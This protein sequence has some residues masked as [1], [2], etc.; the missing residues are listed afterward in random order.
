MIA[1]VRSYS[2]FEE[3]VEEWRH[4]GMKGV[5]HDAIEMAG[6]L[7]VFVE[8]DSDA[9]LSVLA[10]T[11]KNL[12]GIASRSDSADT[13]RLMIAGGPALFRKLSERGSVPAANLVAAALENYYSTETMSV[14]TAS[15]PISFAKTRVMGVLNV[16]PDSFSDGGTFVKKEDAVK[17]AFEIADQGADIIDIGGE[18][19]RPFS[20]PVPEEMEM[21][22]VLPVLKDVAPSLCIP[23]SIDTTKPSVARKAV[24][25]GAQIVNDVSGLR[26]PRMVDTVAELDV[27]VVLMHMRGNPKTMQ[28]DVKYDEVVGDIMLYMAER[29]GEAIERGVKEEKIM[30]DPGIGFGKELQ[31]NLDIVRRLREFRSM[32]RPIVIGP[33]RKG[34][35]GKILSLPEEERLEGSLAAVA[36]SV[37]NGANIVRV[38]DVKETVRVCRMLDAVRLGKEPLSQGSSRKI[39]RE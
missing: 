3:A 30:L 24:E 13:K 5:V 16:T 18:S 29:M 19:T 8:G 26:D 31:H 32:G 10:D 7:F 39:S 37:L 33:S 9:M 27:P 11:I 12:G 6:T 21:E 1:R 38:H 14:E 28:V 23:I 2:S 17:R 15:G 22:R 20:E 34:F 25:L 4:F 35:I 36:A